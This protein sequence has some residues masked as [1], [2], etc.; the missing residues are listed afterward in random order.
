MLAV[1]FFF[2]LVGVSL[3]V[4]GIL[5]LFLKQLQVV[6]TRPKTWLLLSGG[7]FV[8]L[9]LGLLIATT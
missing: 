7:G 6:T 4:V 9:L 1:S 8:C 5:G 3:M 2:V